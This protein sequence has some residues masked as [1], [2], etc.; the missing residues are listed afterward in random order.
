MDFELSKSQKE[1]LPWVL[2]R[3]AEAVLLFV[4]EGINPAM[5]KFNQTEK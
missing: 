5:N 4:S 1:T 2:K 3:V